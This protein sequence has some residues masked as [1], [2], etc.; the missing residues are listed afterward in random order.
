[1]VASVREIDDRDAAEALRGARIFIA[2]SSFPTPDAGE[3]YW[4]DLIGLEVFNRD[5]ERLG[6]VS[7]L[8]DNGAQS[9][10]QIDDG[11]A[12]PR[13]IPFVAAYVDQVD[14][15]GRRITVDWGLDY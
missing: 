11:D 10:L 6:V 7:A 9:V 14:L 2:R 1:M 3:F 12:S 5:G 4:V 8:L 13:L 15:P